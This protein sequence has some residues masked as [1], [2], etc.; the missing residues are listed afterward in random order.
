MKFEIHVNENYCNT[1]YSKCLFDTGLG[2][3]VV[4]DYDV[5][6][7]CLFPKLHTICGGS[8]P[9]CEWFGQ[10]C[11]VVNIVSFP[12]KATT[13][14]HQAII[15]QVHKS[16]Y[17]TQMSWSR[18]YVYTIDQ[19]NKFEVVLFVLVFGLHPEMTSTAVYTSAVI[20]DERTASAIYITME[21]WTECNCGSVN[22]IQISIWNS[23]KWSRK[24]Y[25][26]F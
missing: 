25:K 2:I 24:D 4:D 7:C 3:H 20:F 16:R 6:L 14:H 21:N 23:S 10:L 22:A 5:Y 17:F 18:I 1:F 15:I 11:V 26:H 12:S 8:V 9:I 19:S 13:A